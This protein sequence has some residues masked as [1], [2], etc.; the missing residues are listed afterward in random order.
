[1]VGG[2]G[3][4][5]RT[6]VTKTTVNRLPRDT[7]KALRY[8]HRKLK[9]IEKVPVD[10]AVHERRRSGAGDG[11]RFQRRSIS[12]MDRQRR[13]APAFRLDSG[14]PL[15]YLPWRDA[16]PDE[17][18]C[19]FLPRADRRRSLWHAGDQA[20]TEASGAKTHS[21]NRLHD[22]RRTRFLT[23]GSECDHVFTHPGDPTRLSA[24]GIGNSN[25]GA[26]E[27]G[28]TPTPTPGSTDCATLS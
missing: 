4:G 12:G 7:R 10:R 26:A 15:R 21:S 18:L 27:R 24:L 11:L 16:P 6:P 5:K 20:R 28:S 8:S 19:Q 17:R 13:R 23:C 25:R 3:G 22:E 2:D 9:L 14:P 1:M